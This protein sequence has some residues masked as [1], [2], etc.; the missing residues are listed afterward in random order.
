MNVAWMRNIGSF[1]RALPALSPVTVTAGGG[2]DGVA[3][4][5]LT[6]DRNDIVPVALSALAVVIGH[7]ALGAAETAQ[8][9]ISV[10][11]SADGVDWDD[12]DAG[13]PDDYAA[14][15]TAENADGTHVFTRKIQLGGARRYVRIQVTATMSAAD[16]DTLALSAALVVGGFDELPAAD[17]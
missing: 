11:D 5:G 15:T 1:L 14:V 8:V 4:N 3:Q 13:P 9:A 10:Q 2:A 16:T 7:A 17:A 12:Y 6:I